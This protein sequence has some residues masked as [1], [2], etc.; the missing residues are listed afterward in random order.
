MFPVAKIAALLFRAL[1]RVTPSASGAVDPGE[2]AW[3]K[4]DGATTARVMTLAAAEK[5]GTLLVFEALSVAQTVSVA[6]TNDA[7]SAV[8]WTPASAGVKLILLS[9][10]NGQWTLIAGAAS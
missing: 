2:A 5:D 3:V 1:P 6:F 7:G 4:L 10:E 9:S 8:T